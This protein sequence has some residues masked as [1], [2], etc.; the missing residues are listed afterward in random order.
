[1]LPVV[2]R[3]KGLDGQYEQADGSPRPKLP[4]ATVIKPV[5]LVLFSATCL[6]GAL[7]MN[8][9]SIRLLGLLVSTTQSAE[10]K[11]LIITWMSS[12]TS[13][14]YILLKRRIL[15]CHRGSLRLNF[16]NLQK[17]SQARRI[18]VIHFPTPRSTGLP[19]CQP[20]TSPDHPVIVRNRIN[21]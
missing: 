10:D 19:R 9:A 21:H 8:I 4:E 11:G 17:L 5:R 18:S 12:A 13:Q 16:P 7:L 1:M 2:A 15:R 3:K 6:S 14:K 20:S